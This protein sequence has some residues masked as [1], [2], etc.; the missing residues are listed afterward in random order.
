MSFQFVHETEW[1]MP[2][3]F[4]D[5]TGVPEIAIDLETYDPHLK[6]KGSG[7]ATKEGHIIGI[8]VAIPGMAWYFPIRHENGGNFDPKATLRWMKDVCSQENTTYV[9][10]NAM[11]DVGWLRCEGIEVKGTIVDTMIAAPLIDENRY[12][13]A[14]NA[15]GRDYLKETKSERVLTEAAK[16]MGLDPKS[17]MYKLP[18]H[19]VGA[20]AEQDAALTLR[21]WHHLRGIIHEDQLTSAFEL[22]LGVF[23]VILDMRT[24]GV[25][26]D[27]EKAEQV[28]AFLMKEEE[29]ILSAVQKSYGAEVNIWAA[30]S[31]AKAFDAAGLEYPRTATGQPSFTKNFLATHQHELPKQIV[32]ARELNKARTTFIDSITRHAHNGRIH[33]DIH[34]LRSDDGG[35]VTGRISYSSPNL[36]Q[37]PSRDDFISPLIRGLFLPEE[38]AAWGSFDYSSQEPRIVVHYAS[39]IHKNFLEGKSRYPMQEADKFVEKYRED[40]RSDFYKTAAEMMGISRSQAKTCIAEGELVLTNKGLVP[41]E[42]VTVDH[43]VWDGVEWVSHDGV[44]YMG[45]KEVI[46]YGNL[47]ATPDH[48]VWTIQSGKIPFGVAASRLDAL[49]STGDAERAVRYVDSCEPGNKTARETPTRKGALRLWERGLEILGQLKEREV[50]D[51]SALLHTITPHEEWAFGGGFQR[52]TVP[53]AEGLL[54]VPAMHKPEGQKLQELRWPWDN[55]LVSI[56]EGVGGLFARTGPRRG[57]GGEADRPDRQQL[58]ILHW[59]PETSITNAKWCEQEEHNKGSVWRDA[60]L[61]LARLAFDEDGSPYTGL[62]QNVHNPLTEI[63][64]NTGG[65]AVETKRRVSK[66]YDLCNAGPRNRFTVSGY[67]VSNCALGIMYGMGVNKLSEQLGLDLASGKQFFQEFNAS[68]PFV[69]ELSNYVTERA[70]KN[71]SIRTL[72]GRKGRFDKWE[73]RSFGVHKPLPFDDAVREYGQPLKRAFTYKALNKL[74]QGSAADQTKK[75]MVELHAAG[76]PPMIQIHDELAVSVADKEQA[77]RIVQIMETCVELEIP[78]VVDAELGPSWGEAKKS[79][80]EMFGED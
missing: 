15:L 80:S 19:F 45:E 16:S 30:A 66:V 9:F 6:T 40:P 47:T 7:W 57:V 3:E 37:L 14:L 43:L 52:G 76:I 2:E 49:V 65:S 46:T 72:L 10:H 63:W 44:V 79:I 59:E 34:A 42:K 23:R 54:R 12:S 17:E 78:S 18:A 58:G 11:Y 60:G 8:A 38:G 25:R 50:F 1:V 21:L 56:G 22:E 55:L 4:P 39:I 61:Y 32:R 29:Q 36:Q 28:K 64:S 26:V 67:L 13:Y 70:E 24:R 71:G 77:Q 41:I 5:L 35:T 68:V 48:D 31:V 33:A 62:R 73:P 74:I 75:A 69:K 27:L 20:Y 51:V 53:T